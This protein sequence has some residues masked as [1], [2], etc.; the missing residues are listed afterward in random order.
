VRGTTPLHHAAGIHVPSSASRLYSATHHV[1]N[2][3]PYRDILGRVYNRFAAI[4][5][6]SFSILHKAWQEFGINTPKDSTLES[7]VNAVTAWK[8][9]TIKK[10][11]EKGANRTCRDKFGRTPEE[12]AIDMGSYSDLADS[13]ISALLNPLTAPPK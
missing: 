7:V 4:G 5:S 6:E 3:F 13:K 8:I 9:H 11:I 2:H 12:V 1:S 10:L